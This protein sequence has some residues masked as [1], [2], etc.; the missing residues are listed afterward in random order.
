MQLAEDWAQSTALLGGRGSE[1]QRDL[2]VSREENRAWSPQSVVRSVE[3]ISSHTLD[4]WI[5]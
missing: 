5:K 2:P 4:L 3:G 1:T